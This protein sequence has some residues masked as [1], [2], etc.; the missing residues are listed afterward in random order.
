MTSRT[1]DLIQLLINC[2]RYLCEICDYKTCFTVVK[3]GRLACEG[4]ESLDYAT[5]CSIEGWAFYGLN[6]L[7]GCR[8][9]FEAAFRIQDQLLPDDDIEV[10]D[11][12]RLLRFVFLLLT[13]TLA[14]RLFASYG[15]PRV[16]VR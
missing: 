13:S 11:F 7:E 9:N 2:A 15:R 4:V 1:S 3:S 10:R 8:K 14:V 6:D 16:R 12:R 5:L